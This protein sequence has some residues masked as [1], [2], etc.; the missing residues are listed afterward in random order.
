M[1]IRYSDALACAD[2]HTLAKHAAKEIAWQQGHAVTFISKWDQARVGSASH[3]HQSLTAKGEPAFFDKNATLGKSSIMDH[4]LAGLLAHAPDY[5]YFLAPYINSYKR[6]AKGSFAPTNV[7][8]SVDNRT[9]AFRLCGAD[10]K[11][12]RVECRIPGADINPYLAQAAMLAAGIDGIE[13]ALPLPDAC[14]GDNY[15]ASNAQQ[16]PRTLYASSDKLESSSML[17]KAFGEQVVEHY[18][19]CARWELEEF[20]KTVTNWEL[21]RGFERA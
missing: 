8:W 6:F 20:E 10:S 5:T 15:E 9:S 16:L 4:Y 13:K 17:K 18:V 19:R 21:K 14:S 3:V 12:I 1:N 2:H 7:V 11:S